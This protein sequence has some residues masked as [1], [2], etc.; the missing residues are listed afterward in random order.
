MPTVMVTFVLAT[1]VT[2]RNISAVCEIF[3]TKHKGRLL[4]PYSKTFQAEHF[5]PKSCIC[6]KIPEIICL[7]LAC[8]ILY[9]NNLH[10]THNLPPQHI[11][12]YWQYPVVQSNRE[13]LAS[14]SQ[15]CLHLGHPDQRQIENTSLVV[16]CLYIVQCLYYG[17]YRFCTWDSNIS[18]LRQY[19]V[20]TQRNLYSIIFILGNTAKQYHACTW[21]SPT[22]IGQ[23]IPA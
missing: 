22:S 9:P 15:L 11:D 6:Q 14:S 17:Q 20:C 21:D 12:S 13:P 7:P 23:I 3:L 1:F 10:A 19:H 18:L 4:A 8:I 16:S 2:I 5:R